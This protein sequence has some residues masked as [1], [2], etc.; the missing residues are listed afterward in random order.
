M[1]HAR[2]AAAG[3]SG[4]CRRQLSSL[5]H[6]TPPPPVG[7]DSVAKRVAGFVIFGGLVGGTATLCTWQ[8]SRYFWKLDAIEQ[9]KRDLRRD[10]EALESVLDEMSVAGA[11]DAASKANAKPAPN[12]KA[13][14]AGSPEGGGGFD[15]ASLLASYGGDVATMRRVCVRGKWDH[16]RSMLVG[17]RGSPDGTFRVVG[18]E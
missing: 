5:L 8:T 15:P 13:T 10:P 7:E 17:R 16:A 6:N 4:L 12:A 2:R 3:T 1:A 14:P 18:G 11:F 9:R